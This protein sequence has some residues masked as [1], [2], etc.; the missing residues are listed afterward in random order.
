V[1]D[2]P[3][4][5]VQDI[6]ATE[7]PSPTASVPRGTI[8]FTVVERFEL[9]KLIRTNIW[10]IDASSQN[11]QLWIEGDKS[12]GWPV[13]SPNKRRIAYVVYDLVNGE[14]RPSIWVTNADGLNSHQ[15]SPTYRVGAYPF[16]EENEAVY[17]APIGWGKDGKLFA[18]VVWGK[19]TGACSG[20]LYLLDTGTAQ[21]TQVG[22]QGIFAARWYP[23]GSASLIFYTCKDADQAYYLIDSSK[24][25]SPER[26]DKL[27]SPPLGW[28][29]DGKRYTVTKDGILVIDPIDGSQ[30]LIKAS[31]V[32]RLW[33]SPNGQ[34]IAYTRRDSQCWWIEELFVVD[35]DGTNHKK[36]VDKGIFTLIHMPVVW[37]PDSKW[38]AGLGIPYEY[39]DRVISAEDYLAKV[40][41][42]NV[43][44]GDMI[45]IDQ[46]MAPQPVGTMVEGMEWLP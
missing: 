24:P 46:E 28:T 44:T 29:P 17:L 18:Y 5:S 14:L 34:R 19:R 42:V 26:I 40:Y 31:N 37:S 41:M 11:V 21:I 13:A 2:I 6:R 43:I 9:E 7:S 16:E 23:E 39:A 32:D 1:V 12:K 33:W 25:E 30:Y 35:S 3:E 27:A 15:V 10:A 20:K 38:I 8:L 22:S 45:V 36:L 4:P